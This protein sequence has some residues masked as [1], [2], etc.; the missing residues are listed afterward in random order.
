L[1]V[2]DVAREAGVSIAT[3]SRVLTGSRSVRPSSAEAVLAAT[4]RLGYRPNHLGRAL[5]RQSA[6]AIGMIVPRVDNPFFPSVVQAA[7]RYLRRHG[8]ALLLSTCDDD[9]VIEGQ[10]VEMLVDR[11]VDGLLISPCHVTESVAAIEE[12]GRHVPVLQLDRGTESFDGDFVAVDDEA[13]IRQV[14]AHLRGIGRQ[15]L[16]YIG[17]DTRSWSGAHRVRAFRAAEPAVVEERILLGEFSQDW[18][19]RA[20]RQLLTA[21]NPPDAI[22]CGNDLIAIGVLMAATAMGVHIPEDLA[23]TGYDDIDMARMCQPPLT[24]MRQPIGELVRLAIETLLAR[25]EEP[26]R[27]ATRAFLQM[28][29][30]VRAS[31]VGRG[32]GT[33]PVAVPTSVTHERDPVQRQNPRM[34]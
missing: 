14:V 15:E 11:H 20:A 16:A 4:A 23:V 32:Q 27:S 2:H 25:L 18:G 29:L 22:V 21:G 17:A 12:A 10:R 24:T 28:S 5:R 34:V 30:V 8:Y 9:P 6:Q 19:M 13:G 33:A 31:T 7:E 1:S 26:R 3:V